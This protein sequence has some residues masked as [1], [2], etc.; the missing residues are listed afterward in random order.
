MTIYFSSLE[1]LWKTLDSLRAVAV[2]SVFTVV[3]LY[4]LY[5]WKASLVSSDFVGSMA[6]VTS[7]NRKV[8]SVLKEDYRSHSASTP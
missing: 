5:T 2:I 3:L 7:S 6:I 1:P 8:G 4:Q